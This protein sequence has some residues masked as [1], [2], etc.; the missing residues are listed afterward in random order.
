M[1]SGTSLLG[2]MLDAHPDMIVADEVDA[3]RHAEQGY[4]REGLFQLLERGARGEAEKGRVTARR[5]DG[6]YAL[7]VP[8]GSQGR[9]ARPLVVGDGRAGPTTQALADDPGRL[10]RFRQLLDDV[11]LGVIQ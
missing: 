4:T 5:L 3:L 6:G 8:G 1:K 2:A 10:G 11:D 9:S 7:A